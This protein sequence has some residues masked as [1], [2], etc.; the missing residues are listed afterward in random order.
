MVFGGVFLT[1]IGLWFSTI[2]G[3]AIVKFLGI[4]FLIIGLSII[5]KYH[6]K[7]KQ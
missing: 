7:N 5:I 6:P 4:A 2:G 1:L 3:A